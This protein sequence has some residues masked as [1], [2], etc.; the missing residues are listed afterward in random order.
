MEPCIYTYSS[1]YFL[2]GVVGV[3]GLALF[4]LMAADSLKAD[5]LLYP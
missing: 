3:Q 2:L 1:F 5:S 4:S